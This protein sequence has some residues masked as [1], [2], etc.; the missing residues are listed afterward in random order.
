MMSDN[1][2]SIDN[3]DFDHVKTKYNPKDPEILSKIVESFRPKIVGEDNNIKLLWLACISKDLPK[4]NRLSVIITSQSSAGKSNLINTILE[5]FREDVIDF[6]DYTPAYLN[7]QEINF[8]GKIFKMEQMEKTNEK[9]QIS[10]SNLKF[11]LTEG[12]LKIG[13]VEKNDKGK[14]VPTT[15]EVRGIP[16][17]LSTST[18]YNI[19]P[20]TLNRTLL[21]QV[22]ETE[23]QTKKIVSYIF[24]SYSSLT[25]NDVWKNELEELTKIAKVYKLLAHQT[26]DIVI[27]F[28]NKLEKQ[29]PTSDITI[30][31]DLQKIL[32]L[33]CVVAFTHASNRIRIQDNQGENY[34]TD[35]FGNTEKLYTYAIVPEPSDFT[36]ALSIAGSTIQQT[37]NKI[38]K[39]SMEIY[40]KF[41]DA[42]R[43]KVS[44]NSIS[45]QNTKLDDTSI[46]EVGLTIKELT[47]VSH[48]SQNRTRELINQLVNAGFLTREKNKSR[49]FEYFPTGKKFE[50]IKIDEI[51]F[52][53]DELDNWTVRELSKHE[54]RFEAIYPKNRGVVSYE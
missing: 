26:R 43:Q 6:T 29:I 9:H 20:E 53:K 42:Y 21:M 51:S 24:E 52:T 38:N 19:D 25:I 37:L 32:N 11:L 4:K 47:R 5:P 46:S 54:G 36:E 31:R 2:L 28:G 14:N 50:S 16:V 30:R 8:N 17:F 27:P 45:G 10:L 33:T 18:N 15:L 13:L 35:T 39:S 3:N 48:L 23:R 44:E 49:E 40:E 12:V 41:M 34:F 22:D 1:N 7:R